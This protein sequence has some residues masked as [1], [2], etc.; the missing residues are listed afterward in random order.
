M[1]LDKLNAKQDGFI[2]YL[3]NLQGDKRGA[4]DTMRKLEERARQGGS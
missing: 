1:K 3:Q 2:K 4:L